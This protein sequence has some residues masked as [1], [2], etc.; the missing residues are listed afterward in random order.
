MRLI[1]CVCKHGDM[2]SLAVLIGRGL[3]LSWLSNSETTLVSPLFLLSSL[4]TFVQFLGCK[5][6]PVRLD[7]SFFLSIRACKISILSL[8]FRARKNFLVYAS[9]DSFEY[10][11]EIDRAYPIE[12]NCR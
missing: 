7:R 8:F 3:D 11:S 10:N 12:H 1:G 5:Q 2:F 6:G 4:S 9:F